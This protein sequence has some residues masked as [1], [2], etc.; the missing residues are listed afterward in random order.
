MQTELAP[1]R[2]CLLVVDVQEKLF[3]LIENPCEVLEKMLLLIQGIKL[4]HVPIFISEQYPKGLGNTIEAIRQAAGPEAE[5]FSKT[6]FSCL[7]DDKI[8][9]HFKKLPRSQCIVIGIEA[10]VCIFQT[11]RSLI[12]EGKEVVVA[13]DAISSRSIYD[14]STSIAEMRDLGARISSTET[15]LFELL[16]DSKKPEFKALSALIKS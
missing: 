16:G 1:E 12:Q 14:F 10:H 4:L 3:P 8:K 7:K 9:E 13:N 15:I 11:V 6:S 2:A 5:Y